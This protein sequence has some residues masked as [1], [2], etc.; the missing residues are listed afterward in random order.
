MT[1]RDPHKRRLAIGVKGG[2]MWLFPQSSREAAA[3][4]GLVASGLPW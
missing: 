3:A 2:I 4:L 1:T